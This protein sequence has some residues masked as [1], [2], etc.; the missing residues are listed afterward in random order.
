MSGS[1]SCYFTI[2]KRDEAEKKYSEM[3]KKTKECFV[4]L[5]LFLK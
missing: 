2:V 1:G 3:V 5:H 4:S